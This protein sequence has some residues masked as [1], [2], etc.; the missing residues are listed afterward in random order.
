[1]NFCW[2]SDKGFDLHLSSASR[3]PV[4]ALAEP[5][6]SVRL[7]EELA[8][9]GGEGVDFEYHFDE[10]RPGRGGFEGRFW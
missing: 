3:A 7:K 6:S 1:V 10:A 4:S 2:V 9:D 5:R 8:R